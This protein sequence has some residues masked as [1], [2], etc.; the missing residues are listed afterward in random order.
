VHENDGFRGVTISV[1]RDGERKQPVVAG[2]AIVKLKYVP[3]FQ[4][5]RLLVDHE[6]A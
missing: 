3:T 4:I 5:T 2:A 6:H 1:Q